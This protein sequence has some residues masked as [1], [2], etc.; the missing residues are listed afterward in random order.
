[1]KIVKLWCGCLAFTIFIAGAGNLFAHERKTDKIVEILKSKGIITDQDAASVADETNWFENLTMGGAVELQFQYLTDRD[2]SDPNTDSTSE[3]FLATMQLG[4]EAKVNDSTTANVVL[5]AEDVG[6]SGDTGGNEKIGVDEATFTVDSLGGTPIY[7]VGGKRSLPFGQFYTHTI[8]DPVTHD[9]YEINKAS[10]T[11]GAAVEKVANLDTSL[12]VYR[13]EDMMNQIVGMGATFT[14]DYASAAEETD[15]VNSFIITASVTPMENLTAGLAYASEPGFDARNNTVNLFAEYSIHNLTFDAEYFTGLKRE[16]IGG[17]EYK[18]TSFAVGFA[19][20][21]N[22]P[23]ELAIRYEEFDND[24]STPATG[25]IDY[26]FILGA[27][28]GV[29]D[30]LDLMFEVRCLNEEDGGDSTYE[31]M[32]H[33]VNL[34]L[35]A[36]F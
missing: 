2:R 9:A 7:L 22:D 34:M 31:K 8:S 23:L 21:V 13:G 20:Q 5:L 10:L 26:N 6:H 32:A 12:T 1:M 33:E 14:R 18:E 25:D 19:Y 28:Y 29:M 30:N 27:N 11:I 4:I 36:G 35:A 15:D 24:R 3:L 17:Q 16:K